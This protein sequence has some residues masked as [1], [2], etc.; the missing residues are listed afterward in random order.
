MIVVKFG[1]SLIIH[2]RRVVRELARYADN[3]KQT[4]L[5]I[6]GGS[7]FAN[8]VR[9]IDRQHNL[10]PSAAHWMAVLAMEQYGL[11]LCD[12]TGAYPVREIPEKRGLFVLLPSQMLHNRDE[13]EHSWK[14]TSDTI[15]AWV[16]HMQKS[17]FIKA[18]DVEGIYL[19]GELLRETCASTLIN[20]NTC[21]DTALPEFLQ[22]NAMDCRV[23]CGRSSE[24]I[25]T[26]IEKKYG[27]TLVR[28]C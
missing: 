8:T 11:L 24:P 12:R 20:H 18:T 14:V 1:G 10:S 22:H 21:L 13:L 19:N 16:A 25:I 23:V 27:G 28:G 17:E 6:P 3:S 7:V 26:A 5:L 2:A 4:I 9:T 15:A